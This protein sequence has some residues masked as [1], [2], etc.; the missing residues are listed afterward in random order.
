MLDAPALPYIQFD[1]TQDPSASTALPRGAIVVACD[2]AS[3]AVPAE[4][5]N[6]GLDAKQ[7]ERHIAWDIGAGELTL[8]LARRLGA[9]AVLARWSRLVIDCNRAL[10]D[11]TC[12]AAA[13]DGVKI[14]GNANLTPRAR[15]VRADRYWRPYHA[16]IDAA[17]AECGSRVAAP[18]LLAVHSFTP[19]MQGKARPWH[20]GVLW[21][22][23]PR[24]AQP[25]IAALRAL[26]GLVIGD[27][28]PYSGRHSA[29][30]T[31]DTHA[32]ARG[33]PHVS[34]E[35]RQ[36]LLSTAE[37]VTM[38]AERLNACLRPI[39]RQSD[40]YVRLASAPEVRA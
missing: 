29:D 21:D 39:L 18:V 10:E 32:E 24:I 30:Y 27:N 20:A 31:I 7:L 4:L 26:P 3:A 6:L 9:R 28:Q 15:A 16:A 5:A 37:G 22:R 13:S 19:H 2:H 33:L 23:D 12:I 17:L 40:L 35:V 34:I 8:A 38:W 1:F 36:D 14:P 11:P 25:L